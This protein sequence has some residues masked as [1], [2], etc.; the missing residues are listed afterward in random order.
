MHVEVDTHDRS[1]AVLADQKPVQAVYSSQ[2][3]DLPVA[4]AAEQADEII[5]TSRVKG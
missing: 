5:R 2:A 3:Y 4:K 1:G